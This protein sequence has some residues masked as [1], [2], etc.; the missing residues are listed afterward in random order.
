MAN[1]LVAA[2]PGTREEEEEFFVFDTIEGPRAPVVEPGRITQ[3]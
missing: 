1:P 2:A 3:S